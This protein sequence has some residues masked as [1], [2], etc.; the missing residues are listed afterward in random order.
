MGGAVA[1]DRSTDAARRAEQEIHVLLDE[2]A[3][4]HLRGDADA[5]DR[6]RADDIVF[7]TADGR[8]LEK[9]QMQRAQGDLVLSVY[10]HDDLRVRV[11]GDAA[12]ATGRITS[13]G[14]FRGQPRGGRTRFTRVFVKRGGRWQLVANQLTRIV[15]TSA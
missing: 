14:T 12:V 13:E 10:G 4:A 7:T 5:L 9:A 8:V 15:P 11:Y 1:V 3:A 6:I 2:L